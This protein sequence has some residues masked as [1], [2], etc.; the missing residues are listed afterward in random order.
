MWASGQR[1]QDV[2]DK[3]NNRMMDLQIVE[4]IILV[5]HV[6]AALAIIGLVLIQHGKGA[7]MGSGFG[8]GASATVF[9]SGGAGNFLSKSTSAIAIAFFLT[10]FGLAYFAK[11][12]SVAA[13]DV[14]IPAAIEQTAPQSLGEDLLLP[15]LEQV[16]RAESEM[17]EL[18]RPSESIVPEDQ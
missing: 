3:S 6:L 11:T 14:G 1:S 9:G 15:T 4:T 12:Q 7:D 8:S 2:T 17:P 16:E 5:L 18:D 10:S 13:R